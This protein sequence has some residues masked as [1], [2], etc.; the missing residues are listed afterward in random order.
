MAELR[1]RV[2]NEAPGLRIETAQLMEDLIGDLTAVPQPIE[3]KIF[4]D[5][6]ATLRK[7]APEVAKRIASVPGAVEIF[8]GITIA[9]DA[10]DIRVNR[11]KAAL[12][13]ADPDLV[14]RQIQS[15]EKM[16]GIRV[17]T[18]GDL[19]SRI[20]VLNELRI[21]ALDGHYLP[22]KRVADIGITEGQAQVTRE[23]LKQMVAVTARLE[24]RDLG[25]TMRDVQRV[26]AKM[27]LP[28]GVYIEYGGLYQ[29]Q[30]Q[31]FRD[32]LVVFVSAVMLVTVL[33]LFLYERFTVVLSILLT[34]LLAL[35]GVF[36]GLFLTGTEL[37]VSAMMGMTMIVGIVT[38]V[39]IFYFAELDTQARSS[40]A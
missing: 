33:L 26:L 40:R 6:G 8:D 24:G 9:G 37:N 23:N 39:A 31:S 20:A 15:G 30:Q 13:S 19:R 28:S 5:D 32:L 14:V 34:T 11:V 7:L 17:W 25:S 35:S 21:R 16:I 4:G 10:I 3:V 29:E 18:P 36:A 38:E 12:E 1:Q 27:N 2:E 22:L